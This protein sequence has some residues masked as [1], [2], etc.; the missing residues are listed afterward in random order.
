M[1]NL[2]NVINAQLLAEIR[3]LS[4]NDT[5]ENAVLESLKQAQEGQRQELLEFLQLDRT[6]IIPPKV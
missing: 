4:I 5:I 2:T 3:E 6:T 1:K